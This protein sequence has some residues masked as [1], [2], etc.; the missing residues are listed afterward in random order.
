MGQQTQQQQQP[1]PPQTILVVDD[2]AIVREPIAAALR[3]AGYRI[4]CAGSGEEAIQLVHRERTDLIVLDVNMPGVGGIAVL[5][6]V[7]THRD[8]REMPV[9]LLTASGDKVHVLT[10]AKLGVRD[11]LLKSAFKTSDLIDRVRKHLDARP[12]PVPMATA[13]ATSA[14]PVAEQPPEDA[15]AELTRAETLRRIEK[16]DIKPVPAAVAQLTALTGT[17][18]S[19]VN[20]IVHCLKHDPA[21]SARVLRVANSAAFATQRARVNSV[22][23][24]VR[25]IGLSAVRNLASSVCV[26]GAVSPAADAV[27]RQNIVV[28]WQHSLAVAMVMEKLAPHCAECPVE[29]AYLVGL[30]HE[31]PQMILR[32]HFPRELDAAVAAARRE[33]VALS[34]KLTDA[35]GVQHRELVE[36]ILQRLGLPDTIAGPIRDFSVRAAVAQSGAAL[37]GSVLCRLVAA[38]STYA[39]GLV[40]TA[41]STEPMR[42]LLLSECQ[43]MFGDAL[44]T[45]E[46][47]AMRDEVRLVCAML[48]L[49]DP[50]GLAAI[51]APRATASA[52]ARHP[53]LWYA[54]DASYSSLDA[55]HAL[56]VS[57]G[58]ELSVHP[59]VSHLCKHLDAQRQ[60]GGDRA[61][62]HL[63]IF[64]PQ[65]VGD[66]AAD[67]AVIV[68]L[69]NSAQSKDQ[70]VRA[71][72][73]GPRPGSAQDASESIRF[74]PFPTC[75]Q[76]VLEFLHPSPA[77]ATTSPSAAPAAAA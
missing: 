32:Q 40:F 11:Y 26:M 77:T 57:T 47:L 52:P 39:R 2:M 31:L 7:R 54:R 49:P 33:N 48:E 17:S 9:I 74:A 36:I 1:P 71:L 13:T 28:N 4:I 16:A 30:C 66:H 10:A 60:A 75:A 58:H 51:A 27:E 59:N 25:H 22:E 14:T 42:P 8:T 24:A 12:A 65:L 43:P 23:D 41:Q 69:I 61:V 6:H 38:A 15:P 45:L 76:Q 3:A 56:L 21:L 55:L 64:A 5:Q 53:R 62:E 68:K 44:P 63:V 35:F 20:D 19:D 67:V 29:L 37:A 50:A 70:T 18:R 34:H 72:V 73:C 46:P